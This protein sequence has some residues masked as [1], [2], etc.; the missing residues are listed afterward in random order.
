[1]TRDEQSSRKKG[2]DAA[3]M[4]V[5]NPIDPTSEPSRRQKGKGKE[6]V[7]DRAPSDLPP[8]ERIEVDHDSDGRISH[9]RELDTSDDEDADETLLVDNLQDEDLGMEPAPIN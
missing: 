1:M 9:S 7:E 2:P 5:P 6:L 3:E 8:L 4:Q